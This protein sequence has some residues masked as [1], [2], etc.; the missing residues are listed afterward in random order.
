MPAYFEHTRRSIRLPSLDY[1]TPGAYFV[2]I[3][4]Y[5]RE[6]LFGE[7]VNGEMRV[8]EIGRIV[9]EEW[10]KTA[11]IRREIALD[12]YVIMPN[13]FHGIVW[14]RPTVGAH[15][16]VP[17]THECTTGSCDHTSEARRYTGA[18]NHAPLPRAP[19][20]LSTWVAGFKWA[21]TTHI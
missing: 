12:E 1:A 6:Y 5:E 4:T 19:K 15:G 13:H 18:H 8:D 11:M 9:E 7:T 10:L 2:T 21:T 16:Y 14:I 3:C 17:T 20:S